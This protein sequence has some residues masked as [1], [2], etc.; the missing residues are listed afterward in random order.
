M[1]EIDFV[2]E[3]A[4]LQFRAGEKIVAHT[5]EFLELHYITY[6]HGSMCIEGIHYPVSS[7]YLLISFPDELHR[8]TAS[9]DSP[10]ISQYMVAFSVKGISDEL[11]ERLRACYRNGMLCH[12]AENVMEKV[13]KL[14]NKDSDT[15]KRAAGMHLGAFLLET[16]EADKNPADNYIERAVNYMR[17]NVG[18]KLPLSSISRHVGLEKS[19]FCRR[20]KAVKGESPMRFFMRLKVELA[21]ELLDAGMKNSA[22]ADATGFADEFHFSRTFKQIT[23]MSPRKYRKACQ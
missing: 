22:I 11:Y 7:G 10:Y 8:I 23:G 21:R 13:V 14:Y 20:F 9:E 17:N 3:K 6:G 5:H 19:Y 12:E 1:N 15:L 2:V 18:R 4:E 16:M